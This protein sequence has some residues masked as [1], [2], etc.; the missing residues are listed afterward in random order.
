MTL[1]GAISK[2]EIVAT[3]IINESMKGDDFRE[4]MMK[5]LIEVGLSLVDKSAFVNW[6]TQCCYC[7]S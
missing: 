3:K 4:F 2:E 1:I 7:A 6:M 5:K